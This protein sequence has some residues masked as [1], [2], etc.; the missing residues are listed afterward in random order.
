MLPSLVIILLL[1]VIYLNY[2]KKTDFTNQIINIALIVVVMA[3]TYSHLKKVQLMDKHVES[4]NEETNNTVESFKNNKSSSRK[5]PDL[6]KYDD[7][8]YLAEA[9]E[10]TTEEIITQIFESIPTP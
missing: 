10:I 5:M 7:Q 1:I 3:F 8:D 9:E 6:S 2:N 4:E